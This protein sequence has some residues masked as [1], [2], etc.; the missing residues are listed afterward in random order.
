MAE[1]GAHLTAASTCED[2]PSIFEVV[3]Q[4]SL[5]SAVRPALQ[6]VAKVLAESNPGR[7][8]FLWRWF[9][10]IY[11]F[12]DLLLQ[13]SYL[14]SCSASFPENIYGLKRVV[15]RGGG[16]KRPGR[17]A[18]AGLPRRQHWKSLCLLVFVPYLRTKLEKLVSRLQEEEDYSIHPP[19]SCWKRFYRAFLAAYPFVNL[20]WEGW[21]LAQQLCYILGGAQHHSPLLKLA[22]VQLVRL[23]GA[24]MQAFEDKLAAARTAPQASGSVTERVWL[25]LRKAWHGLAFS[26]STGL[27]MSVFFLQF[28]EWWYSSENQEA[29]KSL[30]ALPPPPPPLHLD[31]GA[32]AHLLPRLRTVC[33]LCRKIRSNDTALSTSGFVYCYRCA[34]NHVKRHQRCPVTGYATELQ[35]L[36]KL[37]TPEN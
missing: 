17:L 20:A 23:T 19:R 31:L 6:H 3:A 25:A 33:P 35:H 27:S 32:D 29:I 7:Y 15:L 37:Y 10:E 28:L 1:R 34:Y 16:A 5:M 36:V 21:F 14:S 9:D 8:G 22:G 26:L 30:T 4:D 18:T 24:D 11:A 13:Q 2:R 12:V